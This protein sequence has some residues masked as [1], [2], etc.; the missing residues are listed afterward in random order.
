VGV[1][2]MALLAEVVMVLEVAEEDTARRPGA[3]LPA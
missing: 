2:A 3:A 1:E